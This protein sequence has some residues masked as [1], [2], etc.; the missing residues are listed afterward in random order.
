MT[1]NVRN[2]APLLTL[3]GVSKHFGA[4]QALKDVSVE[5]APG[6]VHALVGENGAGKSTLGKVLLGVHQPGDGEIRLD[7]VNISITSPADALTKGLVGISQELSL[8]PHRSVTDNIALGLEVTR[9]PFVDQRA[10]RAQVL[11][12]MR[13]YDMELDPDAQVGAL[14]VAQ[15][16]K[17]EILRA[18]SRQARL[19]VFD[20]PTA[21]LASHEAEQLRLLVRCLA[22]SGKA[23]VYIS[24]FLEEVLAISDTITVLRNGQHVQSGPARAESRD[25][26]ILAMTGR[27]SEHQFPAVSPPPALTSAPVLK[28]T[29]LCRKG[30]FEDINF[31]LR[32]GEI[33]GMAG[34]V[35][36]GRS[37]VAQTIYGA[38][39]PSSGQVEFNGRDV[40]RADVADM[41]GA[42]MAMVPESRREQGLVLGRPI[43]DTVTLPYLQRFTGWLGLETGR[44]RREAEAECAATAVKHGGLHLD[45]DTLSGGNQQKVLFARAAMGKPRF[46][47]ADEPTRGVDVGAKRGIYDL[48]ARL[49]AEGQAVLLISSEIE[50]ILGLCHR[51]LVMARGRVVANLTREEMT[52]NAIMQAAFSGV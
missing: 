8:L 14:P 11:E 33:V 47:I 4:T 16:Q 22:Q 3:S 28:V 7:G 36:A 5:F 46:L 21:R 30:L 6:K 2:T 50:E 13:R 10:T 39:P 12:V 40:S 27:D 48:I 31:E 51:T 15:Q 49:A 42:G 29:N 41:I 1:D 32:A 26:L 24:H 23:V 17:V 19:I 44:E 34:L 9:G 37:D 45:I 25:S 35:G 52:K 20:E 18:L 43:V 38:A